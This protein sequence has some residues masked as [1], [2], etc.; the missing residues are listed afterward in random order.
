MPRDLRSPVQTAI[1]FSYWRTTV[2]EWKEANEQI[3]A[4]WKQHP[5]GTSQLAMQP[6]DEH[7]QTFVL[8][9]GDFLKPTKA[10][11]PG[12]PAMLHPL[13]ATRPHPGPLPEGEGDMPTRLDFARWLVDERSPTAAR[14]IVNRVW[15]TYFGT[16]LVSTSEDFGLQ[17]EA[18]SHPELLDWLAVEF[19]EHGWSLKWLHRLI[20][21]SA[22]YQQSSRDYAGAL[23]PRSGESP[24]G[25]LRLASG[26]KPKRFV[27]S[28][29]RRAAC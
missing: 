10:I 6:R 28:R 9:R 26:W 5:Q 16:G 27:T 15:Q 12:V 2:P 22:T 14:S 8:A 1:V 20:V 7:R 29:W 25:P 13:I 21:S 3:E 23:G 19:M 17:G 11:Q 18:P 24:A 4:L